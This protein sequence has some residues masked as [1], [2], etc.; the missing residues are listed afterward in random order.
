ME[1]QNLLLE[2]RYADGRAELL[3]PFAEELVRLKVEII[4]TRGHGRRTWRPRTPRP[5]YPSSCIPRATRSAPVS[6]RSLARPG[7]NITGFSIVS[8]ELD[9]KRLAPAARVVAGLATRRRA[10]EFDQSV[11]SRRAQRFRAGVPVARHRS[12]SLS[13]SLRQAS[14]R[15]RSRRWLAGERRR[16]LC[17]AIVMFNANRV[18]IMTCC[19]EARVTDH[20]RGIE[21]CWRLARWSPTLTRMRSKTNATPHLSTESSAVQNLPISRSSSQLNSSLGST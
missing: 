18:L 10:G 3:R 14:W 9:A 6:S 13:K 21:V 17:H 15:M 19:V 12:R 2:R 20:R 11:L 16:Y 8:P 5:P 7:G 4:V 1:G